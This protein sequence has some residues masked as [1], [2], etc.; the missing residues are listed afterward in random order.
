MFRESQNAPDN[1][2]IIEQYIEPKYKKNKE[3]QSLYV[4]TYFPGI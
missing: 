2:K 4:P 1:R 3:E